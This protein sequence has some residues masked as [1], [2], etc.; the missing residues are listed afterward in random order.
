MLPGVLRENRHAGAERAGG[1][2]MPSLTSVLEGCLKNN[3]DALGVAVVDLESGL[4]IAVAHNVPYFT[5][6]YLDAIA[7]A[8]VDMFRGKTVSAVEKLLTSLRG[9]LVRDMIK[10][11]QITTEATYHFM[12]TSPANSTALVVLITSRKAD[13]VAGWATLRGLIAAVAPLCP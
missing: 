11:A 1:L 3:K 5:E 4:L 10:E 7:A 6:T 9:S 8:A 13:I 2:T 12:G